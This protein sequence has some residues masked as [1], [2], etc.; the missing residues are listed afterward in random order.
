[1]PGDAGNGVSA[2]KPIRLTRQRALALT[3]AAYSQCGEWADVIR[4]E[5]KSS[6]PDVVRHARELDERRARALD[7]IAIVEARYAGVGSEPT[8]EHPRLFEAD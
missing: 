6:D 7:A 4:H 2:P 3:A 1:V 5:M 8:D